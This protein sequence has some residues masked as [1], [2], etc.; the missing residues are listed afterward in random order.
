M[1]GHFIHSRVCLVTLQV[2]CLPKRM[3]FAKGT[4]LAAAIKGLWKAFAADE[5]NDAAAVLS[6]MEAVIAAIAPHVP[7][8]PP[9]QVREVQVRT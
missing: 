4:A 5:A 9:V 2:E 3:P 8:R 6:V 1:R 7:A